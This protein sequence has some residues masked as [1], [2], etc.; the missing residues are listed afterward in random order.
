MLLPLPNVLADP[1]ELDLPRSLRKLRIC[2]LF[3][4]FNLNVQWQR[5]ILLVDEAEHVEP[6]RAE[7]SERA[8]CVTN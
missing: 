7:H 2:F 8:R 4:L 6:L 1:Q 3:E 5:E